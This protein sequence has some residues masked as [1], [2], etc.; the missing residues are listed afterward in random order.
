MTIQLIRV[1]NF[2]FTTVII[3]AGK[4]PLLYYVV[5][6]HASLEFLNTRKLYVFHAYK[7]YNFIFF[8]YELVLLE[9]VRKFKFSNAIEW[10]LNNAEH[11]AFAIIICLKVYTYLRILILKNDAQFFKRICITVVL[12]NAIGF[13]NEYF[14]N[15]ISNRSLFVLTEDS[16]KDIVMNLIGTAVFFLTA[17]CR[18][19]WIKQTTNN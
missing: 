18:I 16:I 3:Y 2:I 19:Q 12:F 11:I 5:A 1:L 14:Q 10:W 15:A 8:S 4:Y 13:I 7:L 9:R 6:M 17:L